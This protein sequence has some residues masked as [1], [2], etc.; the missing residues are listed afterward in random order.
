MPTWSLEDADA[1]ASSNKYTFYKP[2]RDLIA[3]VRPGEI[4]KLIF[5]FENPDPDGLSGER[6][7]VQVDSISADGTFHGRLQNHPKW[8]TD[9][10][11]DDPIMFNASHIINT[12]HDEDENI[13]EKYSMRCLVTNRVLCDGARVG[14]FYREDPDEER[15]SGWRFTA[16]D[17]SDDYMEHA[18][19]HA[20]V[21]VGRVLSCDDSFIH[22]LESP[23]GSAFTLDPETGLFVPVKDGA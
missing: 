7:W 17:E 1:I 4:V 11:F 15:D 2:S 8:I 19:N 18:D 13:V 22:L 16:N 23:S 9:L 10:K 20:Y 3:K 5:L 12:K 14:Y 21:S 6:M